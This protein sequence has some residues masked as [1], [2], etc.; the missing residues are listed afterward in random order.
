MNDPDAIMR[1]VILS[2][3]APMV[4]RVC[5]GV[6]GLLLAFSALVTYGAC[7]IVVFYRPGGLSFKVTCMFGVATAFAAVST[8][9]LKLAIVGY[10]SS[11]FQLAV[12]CIV[13][14]TVVAVGLMVF[15]D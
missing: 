9:A 10:T 3:K 2:R 15:L 12:R 13:V 8:Y 4:L 5:A 7:A 1:P 6:T 14:V 11:R